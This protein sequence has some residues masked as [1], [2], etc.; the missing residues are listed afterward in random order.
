MADRSLLSV[1][2]GS[3]HMPSKAQRTCE[4]VVQDQTQFFFLTFFLFL[5][6]SVKDLGLLL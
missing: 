6:R 5:I 1:S 4:H 2:S 3:E